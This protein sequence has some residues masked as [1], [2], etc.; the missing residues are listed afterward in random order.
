MVWSDLRTFYRWQKWRFYLLQADS[1]PCR[2][3]HDRYKNVRHRRW[4][5]WRAR[6][7]LLLPFWLDSG[8]RKVEACHCNC[9]TGLI[10]SPRIIIHI[11]NLV[12]VGVYLLKTTK[13]R[14]IKVCPR[15][16]RMY[17]N[18]QITSI[19]PDIVCTGSEVHFC[20]CPDTGLARRPVPIRFV[21]KCRKRRYWNRQSN[22]IKTPLAWCY[23]HL[24]NG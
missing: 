20:R 13:R 2:V 5:W 7:C 4:Y 18:A 3:R 1:V 12:L 10:I 9:A 24:P 19:F 23:C 17:A 11:P 8:T 15:A 6:R 21:E 22:S 16:V 14:A